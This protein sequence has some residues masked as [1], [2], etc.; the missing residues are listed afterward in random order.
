MNQG[1]CIHFTGFGLA[2]FGRNASACCAAG[3]NYGE[4]FDGNTPGLA[5]RA[6]CVEYRLKPAHGKGTYIKAGEPAIRIEVDR[7]GHAVIPC[8]RRIEPMDEQVQQARAESDASLARHLMGFSV[9][10]AWRV[11]PNPKRDRYAAVE[12]PACKGKLNLWQ[13]SLN[14]HVGGE[15]ETPSCMKWM[16]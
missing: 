7:R 10:G 1:T 6:P 5:L 13:S 15:C 14:G 8:G 4:A 12:C 3:V 16:E 11:K 9:A 2:L